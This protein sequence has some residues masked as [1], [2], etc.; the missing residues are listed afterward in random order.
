MKHELSDAVAVLGMAVLLAVYTA[1][2]VIQFVL[3]LWHTV[4]GL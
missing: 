1:A 3:M 4:F 2:A